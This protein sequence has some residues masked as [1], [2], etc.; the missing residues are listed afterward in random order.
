M[1][2]TM[3]IMMYINKCGGLWQGAMFALLVLVIIASPFSLLTDN[4]KLTLR[5]NVAEAANCTETAGGV[6]LQQVT[7]NGQVVMRN[8]QPMCQGTNNLMYYY[9]ADGVL[10]N[11]DT[12]IPFSDSQTEP[13]LGHPDA[14][15]VGLD[16][17]GTCTWIVDCILALPVAL[18]D[19]AVTLLAGTLIE[20]SR[21]FLII[22]G[23]LF[24]WLVD[25]TI[26]QFGARY[27][28]IKTA[29]ETAW[30]AFRDIANILII[31][32]FT[33][34]A[35]GTILG[36]QNYN[37]KKMVAKVLIVAVLINFSL[38]A[39]KMVIDAS[40]YT[41]AQ[42]Y[43]AAALGG[44]ATTQGG[45]VGSAGA[46]TRYGIADQFM[47]L[48]GVGTFG[49]AFKTVDDVAQAKG[50]SWA[51][52]LHGILV[53]LVILGAA[54]VLFYGCFLL[55]SRMIMLI[56]LLG[57]ASAALATLLIPDWSDGH[58]GWKAW[59]DSVL[60]CVTFGPILMILLWVTLN[61]AYA[62]RGAT[63]ASRATLGGALSNPTSGNIE[64]IFSY[65]VI[66]G[67][68]FGT[69]KISSMWAG[70][71]GGFN[72][73]AFV[74]A[75]GVSLGG[76]LAGMLGRG[77]VG[78]GAGYVKRR[79]QTA[80]VAQNR[81]GNTYTAK[82]ILGVA[83]Q[84]GK[85][86][87]RDFNVMN[88]QFGKDISSIGGLKGKWAGATKH[89]GIEG[90]DKKAAEAY[91]RD[92]EML[93]K[94]SQKQKAA[95]IVDAAKSIENLPEN[96][97]K[98]KL[99]RGMAE[100]AKAEL[101]QSKKTNEENKLGHEA[102]IEVAKKQVETV[103]TQAETAIKTSE[104]NSKAVV[105]RLERDKEYAPEGSDARKGLESQIAAARAEHESNM[106]MEKAKIDNARAE[107]TRIEGLMSA[108]NEAVAAAEA[109]HKKALADDEA[110][111]KKIQAEAEAEVMKKYPHIDKTTDE[112][113]ARHANTRALN[114]FGHGIKEENDHLANLAKKYVTES[115]E[116]K[117]LKRMIEKSLK[118]NKEEK[119][120]EEQ[121]TAAAH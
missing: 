102:S 17:P 51:A 84:F 67:L 8:G 41:A 46:G 105:A 57:T 71:I 76:R 52:P 81:A 58:F 107:V 114:L 14:A 24:N 117:A 99:L 26:I 120:P 79:L 6:S 60:W 91:A 48:L 55:V 73:A 90:T 100:T 42:I 104:E 118:E 121:K 49:D 45:Q 68:L 70:K 97:E 34:V 39:T 116:D 16:K 89:G 92:A 4:Y 1:P 22:A 95:L 35:I 69:F 40:N 85:I 31:G 37:A 13:G 33:F 2:K 38:L 9:R 21:W 3:S 109:R 32:I 83:N 44:T 106:N 65:V 98:K 75:L 78:A 74:P 18:W 53:M 54:M 110:F 10:V 64:A 80:A 82:G 30:T 25:N 111:N 47:N 29:V 66:L 115:K 112:I 96:R 5:S 11:G 108:G 59:K 36:L 93:A 50:G 72:Y 119:A 7:Q 77:T 86:T 101:E 23:L 28:T 61:V 12:G 43:T 19:T 88:T 27:L 94:D 20:I 87:K 62:L 113:A 56:F 15:A 63:G 103:R